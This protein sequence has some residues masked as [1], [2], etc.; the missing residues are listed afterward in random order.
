MY[1]RLVLLIVLI[2]NVE[3]SS[4]VL[5]FPFVFGDVDPPCAWNGVKSGD[6]PRRSLDVLR[7]SSS[8][9]TPIVSILVGT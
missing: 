3:T 4:N 2:D 7:N 8:A 6:V 5:H 9:L 1:N